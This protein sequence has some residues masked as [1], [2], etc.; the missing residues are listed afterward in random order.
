VRDGG[1]DGLERLLDAEAANRRHALAE[2]SAQVRD[3]LSHE[4][5][6]AEPLKAYRI[7]SKT[8]LRGREEESRMRVSGQR[9][10]TRQSD[11][12]LGLA[13]GGNGLVQFRDGSVEPCLRSL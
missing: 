5:S 6:I 9:S 10:D 4:Q 12:N 2:H 7:G 8:R 13:Q 11:D 1:C 3:R